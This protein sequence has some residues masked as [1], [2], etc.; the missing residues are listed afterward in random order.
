MCYVVAGG[1]PRG[2]GK[3][4]PVHGSGIS[5]VR[6]VVGWMVPAKP[7]VSQLL[8]KVLQVVLEHAV[9]EL[10]NCATYLSKLSQQI[11]VVV[12]PQHE[13]LQVACTAFLLQL[14]HSGFAGQI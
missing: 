11:S 8:P 6:T 5:G 13:A 12:R 10:R 7:F 3:C 14:T 9:L 4:N 2:R 1:G